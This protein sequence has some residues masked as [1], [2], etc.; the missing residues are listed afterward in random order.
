M[1]YMKQA[2]LPQVATVRLALLVFITQVFAT[3][4]DDSRNCKITA[5][6]VK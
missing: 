6:D 2:T 3:L 5:Q 1:T 4:E